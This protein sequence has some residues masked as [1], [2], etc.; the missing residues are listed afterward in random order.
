MTNKHYWRTLGKEASQMVC[1]KLLVNE[2]C[3]HLIC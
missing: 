1:M 3:K 2:V